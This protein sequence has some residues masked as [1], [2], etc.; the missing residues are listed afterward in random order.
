MRC[1]DLLIFVACGLEEQ[2][3]SNIEICRS[4][5]N[6][7]HEFNRVPSVTGAVVLQILV[8]QIAASRDAGRERMLIGVLRT[9]G[10]MCEDSTANASKVIAARGVVPAFQLLGSR[11]PAV[12]QVHMLFKAE[13]HW[14]VLAYKA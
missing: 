11:L 3:R 12:R 8:R 1:S 4:S 5:D 14:P 7:G 2:H 9:L 13:Y 6:V 10:A